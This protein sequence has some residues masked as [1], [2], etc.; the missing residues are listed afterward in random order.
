MASR[1]VLIKFEVHKEFLIIH[2]VWESYV[3]EFYERF[4][5]R[6]PAHLVIPWLCRKR[7]A[8]VRCMQARGPEWSRRIAISNRAVIKHVCA[9]KSWW[10][11]ALRLEMEKRRALALTHSAILCSLIYPLPFSFSFAF[12]IYIYSYLLPIIFNPL[13]YSFCKAIFDTLNITLCHFIKKFFNTC[14]HM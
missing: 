9:P 8:W 14:K 3:D 13:F 12:N 5:T 7:S 11:A 10:M 6:Y 1:C 4:Q 2:R